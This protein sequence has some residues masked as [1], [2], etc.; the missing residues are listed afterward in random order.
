MK[1]SAMLWTGGKDSA[2]ALHEAEDNGFD[3]R[4]LVTFAPPQAKFLAHPLS[5]IK[6]QAE[7]LSLPHYVLP[8]CA[9]FE[10]GYEAA[11]HKLRNEMDVHC[12][13]TGDIAEVAGHPNWIRERCRPLGMQVYTP[14]WGRDRTALLRRLLKL[15]MKVRFSAVDTRW[16]DAA[17][18]GRELDSQALAEL[19][20]IRKRNGLD[21][22]GEE[23]EYHTLVVD[24]PRFMRGVSI[25]AY[26]TG[27]RGSLAYME[28]SNDKR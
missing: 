25:S 20:A 15:G 14:L 2:L 1:N 9:P 18:V 4:C 13:V 7:A 17:W 11:L 8:V 19:Q 23:G 3:V 26:S 28:I 6:L 10:A 22:C 16:L 5:I 21:L 24:G 27:M 12:V